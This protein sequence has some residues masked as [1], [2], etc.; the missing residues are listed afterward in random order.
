MSTNNLSIVQQPVK[1]S[2]KVPVITNWN[3]LI[4]YMIY[5]DQNISS[6]FY[7]KIGLQIYLGSDS[8][9]TLL[10]VLKQRRNGY[11][12]DVTAGK[13]R[14]F[15]DVRD[16]VN[17]QLCD[18]TIDQNLASPLP[19]SLGSYGSIHTL[20]LNDKLKIFSFNGDK[21]TGHT[22]IAQIYVRAIDCYSTTANGGAIC[23][24]P[25][26]PVESS[27]FY[28][29]AS[30]DLFHPRS[31]TSAAPDS[32]YIQ[33]TTFQA[34]CLD[35]VTKKFL[36]DNPR[37][38]SNYYAETTVDKSVNLVLPHD[39]H[40]IGFL[41]GETDFNSKPHS[42]VVKYYNSS[43][44][45][46]ST[47]IIFNQNAQG[48]ANPNTTGGEVSTDQERLIYFGCGPGNLQQFATTTSRPSNNVGWV[49]Y[50]IR[51][52]DSG[53]N[54]MS[55][56]V[57]FVN[58]TCENN[59][60]DY[61]TRRLA[62]RNSLGCYDYFNFVL[63]STQT[64]EISRNK[65]GKLLGT[66]DQDKFYYND[67]QKGQATRQTTAKL[68]ETLN[69]DYISEEQGILIEKLLMSTDVYIIQN[70]D[71][72]YTQAVVVTDSSFIKKTVVNDKLIQYSITIEYANELNTNS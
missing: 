13:A 31:T 65:Y 3:P 19:V 69:T 25:T 63:K 11:S 37:V 72:T 60:K 14:A 1:A 10:S 28:T 35:G 47:T 59:P 67:S 20:A 2:D 71:T 61:P 34:Y 68:K 29:Q 23:Y 58:Q 39:Y 6:L 12:V 41:N 24:T 8:T 26:T 56:E 46:L 18:T 50:T 43:G 15:F 36:S 40:T 33:G 52:L 17:S 49:N 48:G 22:Q 38:A 5:K 16:I 45:T 30:L 7:Y 54:P 42:I 32:Q 66:F 21:A 51:A 27:A 70:V 44:T 57:V 4:G 53:L 55:E 64:T 62:W 9:G